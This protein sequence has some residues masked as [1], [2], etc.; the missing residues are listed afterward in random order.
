ML[1]S[2]S[3]VLA[4]VSLLLAEVEAQE[5]LLQSGDQVRVHLRPWNAKLVHATLLGHDS[6]GL[7][8]KDRGNDIVVDV[9]SVSFIEVSNGAV[10]RRSM[11][12]KSGAAGL[13]VG[14]VG[15]A[16][17]GPLL[18]SSDCLRTTVRPDRHYIGCME[19]L[20]DGN[21]R[22]RAAAT[23]GAAGAL[24]G[25]LVGAILKL[26]HHWEEVRLD[27]VRF[28]ARPRAQ[29]GLELELSLRL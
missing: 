29:G 16:L 4:L 19:N 8:L 12:L 27:R 15:G 3:I 26:D 24:I 14:A 7:H 25:T 5:R 2:A 18:L 10:S 6:Q 13:L 28:N 1:R 17:A 21:A 20:S 23:F 22:V 11:I 9:D